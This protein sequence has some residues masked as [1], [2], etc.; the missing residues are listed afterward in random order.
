MSVVDSD[1][2]PIIYRANVTNI[3]ASLFDGVPSSTTFIADISNITSAR[4]IVRKNHPKGTV[5]IDSVAT[6]DATTT[7]TTWSNGTKQHLLFELSDVETNQ[8]TPSDGTLDIYAVIEVTTADGPIVV[9][10]FDG[11]INFDGI[12]GVDDPVVPATGAELANFVFAG[13]ISG[14]AA[15]PSFRA[16]VTADLSNDLVTY[17]KIQNVSATDRLLGR[18]TAGAGDI[19]EITCTSFARTILDD[20]TAAAVRTT[21][22]AGTSS[23]S[24]LF[25]SLDFTSSNLTSITTRNATALNMATG[26]ILGRSTA[27]TG[28]VEELSRIPNGNNTLGAQLY[29]ISSV[30]SADFDNRVLKQSGGLVVADWENNKLFAGNVLSVDWTAGK[31]Y[32]ND[33][34][35][36]NLD[37]RTNDL[38]SFPSGVAKSSSGRVVMSTEDRKLYN[39]SVNPDQDP[40][41][42]L[43]WSG[44]NS[45]LVIPDPSETFLIG[46][47]SIP[48][49]IG[50]SLYRS[51]QGAQLLISTRDDNP[52]PADDKNPFE[53]VGDFRSG[54][55]G[56][57]YAFLVTPHCELITNSSIRMW[58]TVPAAGVVA[59]DPP[60]NT[61]IQ[62]SPDVAI[63]VSLV[64]NAGYT[65]ASGVRFITAIGPPDNTGAYAHSYELGPQGTL[66]L[67]NNYGQTG[68]VT[69]SLPQIIL[70]DVGADVSSPAATYGFIRQSA[71][72]HLKLGSYNNS[73]NAQGNEIDIT[74]G[75]VTITGLSATSPTF[76]TPVLG[77]P[78]SG[79]VTNLT[80]T[81]SININGT[82]GETT[83]AAGTFTSGIFSTSWKSTTALATPSALSATQFTGFASTVSGAS[84]MG[85][86]TTNDVSLMNRAGTVVL[87]VGPNTTAVN[88][89]GT[90]NLGA[91][92]GSAVVNDTNILAIQDNSNTETGFEVRNS[93]TGTGGATRQAI[94]DSTGTSLN[95]VL[96]STGAT[97]ANV[98]G[99]SRQTTAFIFAHSTGT[100]RDL[101]IGTRGNKFLTLATNGTERMRL[102]ASGGVS[103]GNTTDPGATNFSV[104]GASTLTGAV[105]IGGGAAIAKVLSA[106][107][108]LDF[109]NTVAGAVS[110]LTI[111]V[112]GAALG[113]TVA[114][115]IQHGS[116]PASGTFTAWVSSANTVTVR[117]ENNDLLTARDPASGTFRATVI[118]F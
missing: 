90:L 104:T 85:Y 37:W 111:T 13:P 113:D 23:F 11:S 76:V 24:G 72:G 29:D 114:L 112:T 98:F 19:E 81:A 45:A 10:F 33:G 31:L 105:A 65:D 107:A 52:G 49:L 78:S 94:V 42:S 106:T 9:G 48:N 3:R 25:T 2:A 1:A 27:G 54:S 95:F 102:H 47:T 55:S 51:T 22:G 100:A 79:T 16:L 96:W 118:Q 88:I 57:R 70:K 84:L 75:A 63:G 86:G 56:D 83:P 30:L 8:A 46:A 53:I 7:H 14:S 68:S 36:I 80:G 99:L 64:G 110:D 39:L 77:T 101:S 91:A 50:L 44:T 69:Y 61:M 117:Y 115:G 103:I 40:T 93:S 62:I 34:F 6:L 92:Y 73:T 66:R 26:K 35:G 20:T 87:G 17:G 109:G 41:T 38:L 32:S 12:T 58:A 60:G 116:V 67:S 43:D 71:S 89:P 5:L 97:G 21:I 108:T 82:V 15:L 59:V 74:S 4:L 18:S 28:A